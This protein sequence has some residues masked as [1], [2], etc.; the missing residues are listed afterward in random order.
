[1]PMFNLYMS[2][3]KQGRGQNK[4][5]PENETSD[6]SPER[7]V[8]DRTLALSRWSGSWVKCAHGWTPSAWWDWWGF[9][10]Q[11]WALWG[12]D[13]ALRTRLLKKRRPRTPTSW[14]AWGK[15]S[16]KNVLDACVRARVYRFHFVNTNNGSH[17]AQISQQHTENVHPSFL[18]NSAEF[19]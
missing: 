17:V 12:R 16:R 11:T 14:T 2:L 1:M 10:I 8:H 13:E 6:T 18:L 15:E 5:K 9:S 7:R 3:Y 4:S 19:L